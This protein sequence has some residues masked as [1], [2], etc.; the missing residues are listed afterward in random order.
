MEEKPT[1]WGM[2]FGEFKLVAE[3][4]WLWA[5]VYCA[6]VKYTNVKRVIRI[7]LFI[8]QEY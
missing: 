4:N 1:L 7:N 6:T 2:S 3:N 8:V 5:M